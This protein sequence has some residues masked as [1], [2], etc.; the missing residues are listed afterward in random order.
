MPQQ[1]RAV[2]GIE[3]GQNAILD[4]LA[5]GGPR[6]AAAKDQQYRRCH[7]RSNWRYEVMTT[8][9]R[10]QDYVTMV[11]GVLLFISPLVFGET[12]HHLSTYAA[13]VLGALLFASGIVAAATREP[14]RSLIVNAPGLVA[15]ITFVAAVV[16]LFGGA[17]GVA[18]TAGIL[19]I[20]T[21]AVG[22]TLRM[23]PASEM[24]SA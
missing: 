24:K 1:E 11:F 10:W 7:G 16:L 5:G 3:A 13:Y 20:L 9:K 4:L 21:V 14:R 19:A 22:A 15:V 17:P 12:S 6:D 8:W 23:G 18:W 2:G